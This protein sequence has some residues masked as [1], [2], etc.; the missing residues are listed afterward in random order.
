MECTVE[1][2][3]VYGEEGGAGALVVGRVV[4]L[5]L[6]PALLDDAGRVLPDRLA[7]VGR[8]GGDLWVRTRE[9]WEMPRPG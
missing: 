5:H 1:E 9:T 6:D 8:M 2:I 4:A 7:A 3:R